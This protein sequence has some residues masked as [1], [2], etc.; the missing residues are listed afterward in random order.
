MSEKLNIDKQIAAID[1]D[2]EVQKWYVARAEALEKLEKMEEFQMVIA[3]GYVNI[4]ADKVFDLLVN[5]LTVKPEDKESYLSQLE[6][7]KNIGRYLGNSTYKGTV[8]IMGINAKQAL[9]AAE[10][11]KQELIA[12][13]A[14]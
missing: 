7:I 1:A 6:T 2:I 13:K 4:E 12:G 14:K 9:D 5:P 10:K 8:K 3:D 11:Q